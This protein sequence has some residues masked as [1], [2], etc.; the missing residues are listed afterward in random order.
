MPEA[1]T[2]LSTAISTGGLYT[3]LGLA[4]LAIIAMWFY[5]NK[6]HEARIADKEANAERLFKSV[7]VL[8]QALEAIKE[9]RRPPR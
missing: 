8:G 9:Q 7:E 5:T 4:I 2:G 6:L 1:A 3:L